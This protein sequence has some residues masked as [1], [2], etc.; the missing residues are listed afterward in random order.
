MR[1]MSSEYCSQVEK[2]LEGND[3]T[4]KEIL[5][6]SHHC[7][8]VPFKWLL[9]SG[10]YA[11]SSVESK[12]LI[13]HHSIW[14]LQW[15]LLDLEQTQ[16]ISKFPWLDFLSSSCVTSPLWMHR[17]RL[18]VHPASSQALRFRVYSSF[19]LYTL[20]HNFHQHGISSLREF[21]WLLYHQTQHSQYSLTL[22]IFFV[23]HSNCFSLVYCYML[24][25]TDLE[26]S[27]HDINTHAMSSNIESIYLSLRT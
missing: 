23:Q 7:M 15:K 16:I 24:L 8:S 10:H 4:A 21:L 12:A 18:P 2:E 26:A 3:L 27:H 6:W 9:S 14:T 22:P 11:L 5:S 13:F 20:S 1:Q 19:C 17:F 25:C